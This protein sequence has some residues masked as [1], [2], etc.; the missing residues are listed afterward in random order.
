MRI[1]VNGNI[2]TQRAGAGYIQ[3]QQLQANPE[4]LS[5]ARKD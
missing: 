4:I 3:R 2:Q 1:I 5:N